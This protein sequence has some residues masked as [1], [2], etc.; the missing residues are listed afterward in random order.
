MCCTRLARNAGTKNRQN[1]TFWAPS[2]N[3]VV[4]YLRNCGTY[5]QSEK[6]SLNSNVSPTCPHHMVNFGPLPAEIC[7]NV[8]GTPTNFNGFRASW[9]RYCTALEYWASAK[10]CGVEH[11][12][13]LTFGKAA[14]TLG[15]GPHSSIVLVLLGWNDRQCYSC[16]FAGMTLLDV[17]RYLII[18]WM[19]LLG[20]CKLILAH[21]ILLIYMICTH[22]NLFRPWVRPW[23]HVKIKLF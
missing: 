16:P 15:I 2:H 18:R 8:L 14:I 12:S 22:G 10:V 11:R 23:F 20:F 7:W 1:F 6:T 5:W 17:Y 3:F 4:L 21:L 9:Q 19:N 13:P